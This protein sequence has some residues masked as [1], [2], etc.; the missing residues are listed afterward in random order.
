MP[1]DPSELWSFLPIGYLLTVAV[2]IPVLL[3][4]LSRR[5]SFRDRLFAGFWLTACTYPM[6]VLVLPYVVWKPFGRVVYLG[7]AE[8][9][10]PLAECVLFWLAHRAGHYHQGKPSL[11]R[12]TLRDFAA[13]VAANLGSF[14]VGEIIPW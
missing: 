14:L 13:I 11:N 2:E 1:P 12:G 3:V 7:V 6:V 10:A 5:H 9:F 4:G 8:T